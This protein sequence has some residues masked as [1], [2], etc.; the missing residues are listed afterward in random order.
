MIID[1]DRKE[2]HTTAVYGAGRYFADQSSVIMKMWEGIAG[3]VIR[4]KK[5]VEVFD[6]QKEARARF[7]EIARTDGLV[8]LIAVP[9]QIGK[10]GFWVFS[11]VTQVNGIPL[12]IRKS[13][14]F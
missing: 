10:N 6:I 1:E 12:P 11:T 9:I 5:P 13:L 4:D 8:S 14:F 7:P 3:R 2:L